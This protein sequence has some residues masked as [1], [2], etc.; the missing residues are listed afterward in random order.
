[1][2]VEFSAKDNPREWFK[3]VAREFGAN[4]INNAFDIPPSLGEG[5]FKHVYFFEGLT[6]SYLHFKLFEPLEFIRYSVPDARLIPIMFYSQD[7][8]FEQYIDE[9]KKLV[10][11]HT[12]NGIFMPSP[13]TESRWMV[14]AGI[15]GYQVTVTIEKNWFLQTLDYSETLYLNHLL[16]SG[17]PFYLFES[18]TPYMRQLIGTIHDL[19]NSEDKLQ[20]LKLHQRSMELLNLF[21]EQLEQRTVVHDFSG[22]NQLDVQKVFAVR[23][24][25]LENLT[26]VPPLKQL[27]LET[28]MSISKLQKCFQQVFGKSISQYALSGKMNLAKQLLDSKKY[29]V[30]EVGYQ[31]GYSNLSHF[32]KAFNNEFGINPKAYSYK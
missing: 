20:N 28:G 1:M 24:Q 22:I 6:L 8:P 19:I 11:Y 12:S 17:N 23:K 30:S 31:L 29:S 10:G 15:E 9:Q 16:L 21:L 26:N 32:S 7:I 2:Q 4:V 18:L 25:L 13:Q 14:P 27:S 5:S 3:T